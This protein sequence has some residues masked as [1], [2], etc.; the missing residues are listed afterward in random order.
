M[1][2][3]LS[4]APFGIVIE[5]LGNALRTIAIFSVL[6]AL[7]LLLSGIYT[8]FVIGLGFVSVLLVLYIQ[9]RMDAADGDQVNLGFSPLRLAKYMFW[10]LIEIA[11]SNWAV[12]KIIL[13]PAMKTRQHL[14][15]VPAKQKT[16]MGQVIF[17]NSITLTPGT[18]S[19]ETEAEKFLVHSLDFTTDDVGAIADM[20]DRVAAT[21]INGGA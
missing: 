6:F 16:D 18:I 14:F 10:L 11:K 3:V 8:T 20:G 7:W 1:V 2:S 19:V 13:S 4:A 15:F 12:T 9:N 5:S 17:A 21:E